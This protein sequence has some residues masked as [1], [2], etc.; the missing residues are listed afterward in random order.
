MNNNEDIELDP[1]LIDDKWG[2]ADEV[3]N[4]VIPCQWL[5]AGNFSEGLAPVASEEGYG[6]IDKT[7]KLAIPYHPDWTDAWEFED[8]VAIIY[9]NNYEEHVIDKSN[10]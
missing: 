4:I 5:S 10:P 8:G 2:Y 9:D 6:Y 3:G 7:G 1:I